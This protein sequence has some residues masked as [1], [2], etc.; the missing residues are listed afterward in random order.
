MFEDKTKQTFA[1]TEAA[2]RMPYAAP[3]LTVLGSV[4]ELTLGG[5]GCTEEPVIGGFF[6]EASPC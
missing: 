3:R 2:G 5:E 4:N 6:G 1:G